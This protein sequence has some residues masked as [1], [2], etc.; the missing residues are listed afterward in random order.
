MKLIAATGIALIL[1]TGLAVAQTSSSPGAAGN[2]QLSDAQCQQVWSKLDSQKS[3]SVSQTQSANYVNDFKQAD[4]NNDGR[5]SSTEFTSAC[6]RGLVR[7]SAAAGS[8]SGAGSMG[9]GSSPSQ[10]R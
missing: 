4:T 8:G 5:L 7:D 2:Q 1:G 6:Q 3:G 10:S 9:S